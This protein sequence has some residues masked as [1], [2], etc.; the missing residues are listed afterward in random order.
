MSD[1][2]VS[3]I[4]RALS[5]PKFIVV[6]AILLL[7]AVTLNAATQALKLHFKKEPV[8]QPRDFHEIQPLMGVWL[9]VSQDEKLDK[10]IQDVLG[11]EKYIYRDYINVPMRGSDFLADAWREDHLDAAAKE[12]A[13]DAIGNTDNE[14]PAV[15][16]L[17]SKFQSAD[18]AH[19][20][21]M[22]QQALVGRTAGDCKKIVYALQVQ[23]TAGVVNMGLTYYTGL[24]DTVAHIPDRCYIADGYE[25]SSYEIPTWDLTPP[26]S[27]T[28]Q[29][30]QVRFISFEDQTGRNFQSKCVAYVFHVNGFYESDPLAVR[31]RLQSLTQRFGYY[32]KV[33]LMTIGDDTQ[34]AQDTMR[35][36]LTAA[37][38]QI[39][40]CLPDWQKVIQSHP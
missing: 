24:V 32:A 7:A 39:E 21:Q 22:I 30:V 19:Q 26:G 20:V 23:Q 27:T 15:G 35:S 2:T 17:R 18:F 37:K 10:E 14:D 25:P 12:N 5:Q 9:Q 13:T 31:Q 36:F 8:P 16:V 34:A 4:R 3:P 28:P 6:C 33:E 1:T 11:T 38:P 40:A 29:S